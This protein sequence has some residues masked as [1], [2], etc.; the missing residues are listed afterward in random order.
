MRGVGGIFAD[1]NILMSGSALFFV[2]VF[3][4]TAF[5][6][7]W[8]KRYDDDV[9]AGVCLLCRFLLAARMLMYCCEYD[10]DDDDDNARSEKKNESS[11][12]IIMCIHT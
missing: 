11:Y 12:E 6:I 3:L 1:R 8:E 5:F 7:P 2:F 4:T 9:T 10:D